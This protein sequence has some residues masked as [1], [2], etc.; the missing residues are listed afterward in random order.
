MKRQRG[1]GRGSA[2][3]CPTLGGSHRAYPGGATTAPQSHSFIRHRGQRPRMS[4]AWDASAS[5]NTDE[6]TEATG[7]LGARPPRDWPPDDPPA[8]KLAPAGRWRQTA[9]D[10]DPGNVSQDSWARWPPAPAGSPGARM[11]E[12]A[13]V[14]FPARLPCLFSGPGDRV[15]GQQSKQWPG[16]STGAGSRGKRGSKRGAELSRSPLF[17]GGIRF[18]QEKGFR[19]GRVRTWV[20]TPGST[21]SPRGRWPK[22]HEPGLTVTLHEK[23]A[24][25]I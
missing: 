5:T 8:R 9:L 12:G 4:A 20:Q 10:A 24:Q 23:E 22:C 11:R 2:W 15:R 25:G 13:G 3:D 7:W 1:W 18:P 16:A 6:E 21:P 14:T 19:A 17:R